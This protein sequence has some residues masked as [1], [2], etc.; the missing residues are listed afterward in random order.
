MV[1]KMQPFHPSFQN[2]WNL[3]NPFISGFSLNK[4]IIRFFYDF[5]VFLLSICLQYVI[6]MFAVCYLFADD[7]SIMLLYNVIV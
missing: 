7:H 3:L 6:V 2:I 5:F 4:M 1:R